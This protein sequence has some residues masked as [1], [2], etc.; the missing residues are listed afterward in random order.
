MSSWYS[1]E[2][3]FPTKQITLQIFDILLTHPEKKIYIGW[4]RAHVGEQCNERAD[5]LAKSV[6][7]D[8]QYDCIE[9]VKLPRSILNRYSKEHMKRDWQKDWTSSEKGRYTYGIL[10]KVNCEFISGNRIL[11][12]FLSGH[13]SFPEYLCKIKKR[14]NIK[15]DCGEVGSPLH[16]LFSKCPLM[17]TGFI[18]DRDRTLRQNLKSVLFKKSNY[19]QLSEIYNKLNQ[20]YSFI[21]YKF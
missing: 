14:S 20:L 16:Y 13:G 4:I 6:I 2:H 8:N 9:D 5:A 12:Y 21:R 11:T 19:K 3:M 17:P 15:C 10:N 1:L 7:D 18:F